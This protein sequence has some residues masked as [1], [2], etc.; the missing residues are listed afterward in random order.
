[1]YGRTFVT[2]K[3]AL[4]AMSGPKRDGRGWGVGGQ[5]GISWWQHL[6]SSGKLENGKKPGQ[7]KQVGGGG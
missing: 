7:M 6:G 2:A 1:M 3:R 5:G 4:F